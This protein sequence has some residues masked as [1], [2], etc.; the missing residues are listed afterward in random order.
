MNPA[1]PALFDLGGKTAIV[2]AAGQGMGR[3]IAQRLAEAGANIVIFHRHRDA[4]ETVAVDLRAL[5]VEAIAVTGDVTDLVA[6]DDLVAATIDRFGAVDILVNN[7]GGMHPFT[8]FLDVTPE[9]WAATTDRNM[10][11]T[12][13]LTQK[14]ARTMVAAGRPGKI[15]NIASTAAFKP[16][17]QLAAY[18]AAK[19]GVISLTRSISVE[20][21]PHRILVNSVVPGPIRTTATEAVYADPAIAAMVKQR[22]PLGGPG[23][24]QDI[25][26]AVLFCASA[27]S[28]HMTGGMIVIDGGFMWS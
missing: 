11:G 27:A 5:G 15:V 12:Y 24:P 18:N 20:L 2:T 28:D 3:G 10:K 9:I 23:D 13:F 21:A 1:I 19:A 4:A 25:G 7:A 6:L 14:V 8:P 22:V 17:Y 16:D 26:N